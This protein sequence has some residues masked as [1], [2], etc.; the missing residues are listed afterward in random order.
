MVIWGLALWSE[1]LILKPPSS[2]S[3]WSSHHWRRRAGR[4]SGAGLALG[5][6]TREERKR[7]EMAAN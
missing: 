3:S 5:A 4:T 6:E 1:Y 7:K 2:I